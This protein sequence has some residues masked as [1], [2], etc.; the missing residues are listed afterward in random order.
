MAGLDP[1]DPKVRDAAVEALN[2]VVRMAGPDPIATF[3]RGPG[4]QFSS[5][6]GSASASFT[7]PPGALASVLI[8]GCVAWLAGLWLIVARPSGRRSAPLPTVSAPV[9]AGAQ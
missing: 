1:L 6:G 4:S 5:R 8:V 3:R 2:E 7:P 9:A